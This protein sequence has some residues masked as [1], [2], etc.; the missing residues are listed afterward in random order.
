MCLYIYI[1]VWGLCNVKIQI[2]WQKWIPTLTFSFFI[3]SNLNQLC[4]AAFLSFIICWIYN[5]SRN[6]VYVC[7][8]N[9][10][11]SPYVSFS[12]SS[13]KQSCYWIRFPAPLLLVTFAQESIYSLAYM[14]DWIPARESQNS[15]LT[16]H[17]PNS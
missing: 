9:K 12:N 8:S 4:K 14:D 3:E 2:K 6:S 15:K 5:W 1:C 10:N 7:L 13:N 11:N 16:D 17:W